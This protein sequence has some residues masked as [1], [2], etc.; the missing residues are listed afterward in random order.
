VGGGRCVVVVQMLADR[1][2]LGYDARPKSRFLKN[3]ISVVL[4]HPAVL[5]GPAGK[6]VPTL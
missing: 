3:A 2:R 6:E 5:E 1:F 4:L